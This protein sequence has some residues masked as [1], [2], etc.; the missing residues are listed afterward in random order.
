MHHEAIA[1]SGN[2]GR[3]KI[4]THFEPG[5]QVFLAAEDFVVIMDELG[6]WWLA[7]ERPDTY[8]PEESGAGP[9]LWMEG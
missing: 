9:L 7:A 4:L 1:T 6:L 5:D 8:T 3:C 2:A